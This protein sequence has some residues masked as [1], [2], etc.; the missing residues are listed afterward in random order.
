MLSKNV[1]AVLALVLSVA[2]RPL[3]A[4]SDSVTGVITELLSPV[5]GSD[6]SASA[7]A[8][9]SG[10]DSG[11]GVS[12]ALTCLPILLQ[13]KPNAERQRQLCWQ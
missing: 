8:N 4:S 11:D 7:S 2:A 13:L 1:L 6:D 10:D 9:D 3:P 5:T 12:L